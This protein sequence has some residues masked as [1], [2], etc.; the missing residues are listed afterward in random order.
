MSQKNNSF[1]DLAK[2][3]KSQQNQVKE[4]LKQDKTTQIDKFPKNSRLSSSC[5]VRN[6]ETKSEATLKNVPT[7]S[8]DNLV[9]TKTNPSTIKKPKLI[10]HSKTCGA[11]LY[12]F[13]IQGKKCVTIRRDS[14]EGELGEHLSIILH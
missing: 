5:E 12:M 1:P 10:T 11:S 14:P 9:S 3:S 13:T 4:T 2:L 6:E 8:F 7:K